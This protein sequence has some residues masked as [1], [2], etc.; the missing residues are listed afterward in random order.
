M[1]IKV[2]LILLRAPCFIYPKYRNNEIILIK[3][4]NNIYIILK[5]MFKSQL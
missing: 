4:L 1:S 5:N 2:L 3:F